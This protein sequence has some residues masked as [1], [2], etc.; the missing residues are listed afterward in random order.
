MIFLGLALL[1]VAYEGRPNE[2]S[3]SPQQCDQQYITDLARNPPMETQAEFELRKARVTKWEEKWYP[4]MVASVRGRRNAMVEAPDEVQQQLSRAGVPPHAIE[5]FLAL[6]VTPP[7]ETPEH[8]ELRK[9]RMLEWYKRWTPQFMLTTTPVPTT[10]EDPMK[11]MKKEIRENFGEMGLP[12]DAIEDYI[13]MISDYPTEHDTEADIQQR[14]E[15]MRNWSR[16]FE[17]LMEGVGRR[18]QA[19]EVASEVSAIFEK[20]SVV[21]SVM[22]NILSEGEL[23]P[24]KVQ[25]LQEFASTMLGEYE[26]VLVEKVLTHT[27]KK[28]SQKTGV[29]R[30]EL[31]ILP[32]GEL[33][34]DF[35]RIDDF[36]YR[37][38]SFVWNKAARQEQT[39]NA[40][41]TEFRK[42]GLPDE[43]INE[44]ISFVRDMETLSGTSIADERIGRHQEWNQR[45]EYL[46]KEYPTRREFRRMG[47]PEHAIDEYIVEFYE[48]QG[49]TTAANEVYLLPPV[50]TRITTTSV[51]QTA[52]P[53]YVTRPTTQPYQ[54][55]TQRVT[56][57]LVATV[58]TTEQPEMHIPE[59]FDVNERRAQE[60]RREVVNDVA[61]TFDQALTVSKVI[62]N[63]LSDGILTN[64]K[65]EMI[66]A[67]TAQLDEYAHG[68]LNKVLRHVIKK[69]AQRN[70]I[71]ME[72]LQS[73]FQ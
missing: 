57:V 30:E 54:D 67:Y 12:S 61:A 53:A 5:E 43:A 72:F 4:I 18:D 46:F 22:R 73:K 58:T 55:H 26:R 25:N 63:Q 29:P 24:D 69:V 1:V 59:Q 2:A 7:G 21:T 50:R 15:R 35:A 20:S 47:I 70:D 3:P 37:F 39:S 16:R 10:T 68:V 11:D 41:R 44:Y 33:D 19:K 52:T 49:R 48:T 36:P 31:Q 6:R 28:I 40:I 32:L 42:I 65:A 38:C 60:G 56:S 45:W 34:A 17:N 14:A 66:Q 9:E 13:D 71:P 51:P 62:N 23:T 64:E 27:I 8:F